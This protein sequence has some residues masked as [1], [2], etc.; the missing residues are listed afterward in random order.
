MNTVWDLFLNAPYRVGAY[1]L[2]E[3][4]L[5]ELKTAIHIEG[6]LNDPSDTD[7]FWAVEMAIP[8]KPYFRMVHGSKGK[9]R[10]N[11]QWRINFSRVQWDHDIVDGKYQRKRENGKRLEEHNWV[12]S[13]M[14]TIDMHQ[15]E[16]WGYIQFS[17]NSD[18][19]KVEFQVDEDLL[20]KQTAYALFRKT[21]L[22]ELKHMRK[23]DNIYQQLLKV[24][25]DSKK[26]IEALFYKT[27]SGFEYTITSPNT[28]K[29]YV[30]N[31][32]GKLK[33]L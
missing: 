10:K 16:K 24:K 18:L 26:E 4:N 17:E 6:T 5:D 12:W 22:G 23:E 13:N 29:T 2:F 7:S 19:N 28:S 15:P 11:E 14:K 9:L 33:I 21:L 20:I 1:P 30:I 3:W 27:N 31:N 32:E 25:Y 8:L